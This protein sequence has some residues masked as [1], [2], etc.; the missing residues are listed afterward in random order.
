MTVLD[1]A[2][3]N[4]TENGEGEG[5]RMSYFAALRTAELHLVLEEEPSG[6]TVKPMVLETSDSRVALVFDTELRMADFMQS[7]VA[8]LCLSG[9][10]IVD[11]LA[12]E[13]IALGVNLGCSS[14]NLLPVDVV[15]WLHENTPGDVAS[16]L[17]QPSGIF[18]PGDLPEAFIEALDARLAQFGGNERSAYLAQ[19][20]YEHHEKRHLLSVVGLP[21]EAHQGLAASV[22]EALH[23]SGLETSTLD[24]SF[25]MSGDAIIAKLELVGLR[26]DLPNA[27]EAKAVDPKKPPRLV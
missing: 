2:Y 10:R 8:Y 27:P 1:Q 3:R 16:V 18:P 7:P 26:F 12:G 14:E 21:A 4:M 9:R 19:A 5:A 11:M 13:G 24:V 17:E 15:S 25:H 6:D 22:A 23:Y 20:E